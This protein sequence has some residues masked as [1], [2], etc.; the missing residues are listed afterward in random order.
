MKTYGLPNREET[1]VLQTKITA[2]SLP[3]LYNMRW[4]RFLT[5][6]HVGSDILPPK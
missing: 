3:F 2:L 5:L 4:N 1:E 6:L